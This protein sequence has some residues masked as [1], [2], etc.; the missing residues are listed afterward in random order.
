MFRVGPDELVTDIAWTT[1]S[2]GDVA[3]RLDRAARLRWR[4][5]VVAD[6]GG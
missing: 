1:H 2:R 5:T 4:L 6:G 3:Q